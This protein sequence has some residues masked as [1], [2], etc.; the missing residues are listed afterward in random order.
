M[1]MLIP[2]TL[3]WDYPTIQA[4]SHYLAAEHTQQRQ[5]SLVLSA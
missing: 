4:I 3:L 2:A 5:P 1:D